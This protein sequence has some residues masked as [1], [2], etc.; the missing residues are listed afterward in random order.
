MTLIKS[1]NK[2]VV[3]PFISEQEELKLGKMTGKVGKVQAISLGS[4]Q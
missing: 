2:P 1:R 3:K 4:R